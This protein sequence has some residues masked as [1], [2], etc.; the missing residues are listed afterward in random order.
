MHYLYEGDGYAMESKF[1]L[2]LQMYETQ[3]LFLRS[4]PTIDIKLLALCHGRLGKMF[5]QMDKHNRAIVEFD[6]QLSLAKEVDDRA[7]EA[8]AY[9]GLGTGYLRIFDYDNAIRYLNIAQALWAAVGNMPRYSGAL[10]MLYDCFDRLNNT[11]NM[12]IFREKIQAVEDN[13]RG[14]VSSMHEQLD[15]MKARLVSTA[16]EIEHV[17]NI[18]RITFRALSL[19]QTYKKRTEELHQLEEEHEEQAA[20]V[21]ASENILDAIQKEMEEA[22]NSDEPEMWSALVHDQPQVSLL[23]ST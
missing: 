20:E 9:H 7:E 2:A 22:L 5:L 21:E 12:K 4:R 17:V 11:D 18:E 15:S 23:I 1:P 19:R 3:V 6:R 16:A 13:L 14:R 10:R 8:D